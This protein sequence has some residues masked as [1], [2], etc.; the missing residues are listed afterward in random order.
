MKTIDEL[1]VHTRLLAIDVMALTDKIKYGPANN[2][3]VKQITRSANSVAANFRATKR[4]KSPADFLN[5]YR[6][7]EEEADET[8]HFLEVM[9]LRFVDLVDECNQ[10]IKE[11]D[12]F[13]SIV[14][15]SINTIKKNNLSLK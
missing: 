4:A 8:L 13:L 7:V 6:I 12:S 2:E 1:I 3:V 10:L 15:S 5:K 9:K 14:V 11:Y